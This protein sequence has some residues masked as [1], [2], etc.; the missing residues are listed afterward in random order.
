VRRIILGTKLVIL[1]LWTAICFGAY[2]LL[3]LIGDAVI[4]HSDTV[5]VAPEGVAFVSW[6]LGLFQTVGFGL[7]VGV[8]VLGVIVVLLSA[9]SRTGWRRGVEIAGPSGKRR[10]RRHGMKRILFTLARQVAADPHMRARAIETARRLRPHLEQA[11]QEIAAAAREVD[12]RR[13]PVGFGRRV[14][15]RIFPK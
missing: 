7:V 15:D 1:A 3:N 10:D 8:W 11:G 13:D 6:L 12:P 5:P 4:R 14:R 9:G 2:A